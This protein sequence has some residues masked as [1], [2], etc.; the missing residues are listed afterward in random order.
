MLRKFA[1]ILATGL[2]SGYAPLI[3][4]T[5]GSLAALLIF[6][7]FPRSVYLQLLMILITYITGVWAAGLIEQEKGDDPG[8]VV[9]DE[10]AG[11]WI[12]LIFVPQTI[13]VY[14]VSFVLFRFFDILKPFPVRQAEKLPAGWGVMTDDI[15][16]GLYANITLQ[17]LLL[18]L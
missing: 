16:A 11:Q 18:L 14:L 10:F 13:P 17:I 4:G 9:I 1:Y 5:A 6:W 15:M 8:L 7:F 2:G 3:P 12:A